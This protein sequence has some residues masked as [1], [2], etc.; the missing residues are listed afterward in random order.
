M[1]AETIKTME[2]AI[3]RA[4]R[5]SK[6]IVWIV[7]GKVVS[8]TVK[9]AQVLADDVAMQIEEIYIKYQALINEAKI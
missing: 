6:P 8:L 9:E 5:K 3:G 2:S 4:R 1:T 7:Q